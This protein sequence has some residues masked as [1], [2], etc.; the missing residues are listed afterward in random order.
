MKKVGIIMECNPFHS[1]HKYFIDKIKESIKPDFLIAITSGY[2]T[3]RGDVSVIS[4]IDKTKALLQSGCNV[5]LELPIVYSL[6]SSDYFAYNAVKILYDFGVNHIV[7]GCENDNL[8]NFEYFYNLLKQ[9]SFNNILTFYIKEKKSYK[10]AYKLALEEQKVD[11]D[12][13]K[14]F[15]SPNFTLAFQYYKTIK[16]NNL[17]IE[18]SLI[19]RTN[20]FD[21]T[22]LSDDIVSAKA[23]REGLINNKDI[24]KYLP[25]NFN[26]INQLEANERLYNIFKYLSTFIKASSFDE[27]ILNYIKKNISDESFD[28]FVTNCSNKRYTKSRIKRAIIKYILDA[29]QDIKYIPYERII[30][31]DDLGKYYISLLNKEQK[32]LIFTSIQDGNK[33]L[34]IRKYLEI[35]ERASL[36]YETITNQNNIKIREYQ[37]PLRKENI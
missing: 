37:L 30:G 9:D 14:L 31:L 12:L 5:V 20:N 1:G 17:D 27:G 33:H 15:N 24:H 36:L 13:I 22:S 23:I 18:F 35:E 28:Q 10:I 25:Y 16:D 4:K 8:E 2:F 7:C 32:A 34:E 11:E 19:K 21:S 3:M 29:T 26:L 6:Q